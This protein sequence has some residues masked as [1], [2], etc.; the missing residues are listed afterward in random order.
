M[1]LVFMGTPEFSVPSLEILLANNYKIA[2]VV[3]APDTPQG[4][5]RRMMPSAIKVVARA[6]N[7]PILQPTNL[8]DPSFVDRLRSYQA[9][10]QVV[11]A[12]RMLPQIVWTMP[13][14]G[15]FNLHASL[16]PAYRGA[17]PINWAI[18]NGEHET[19]ITTFLLAQAM[20]TGD[21]LFQEK[22]PI[23][24]YD[25][26]GTLHERLKYKG[27]QLVLR[28]VQAVEAKNYTAMIQ[29]PTTEDLY[30]KAPK[31]YKKDCRINWAQKSAFI[32]NFIRGLSP[33]PAAWTILNGKT[34]KILYAE[35]AQ[36]VLP[37]LGP[38]ELHSDGEHYVCIGTGDDPVALKQLQLAGSRPKEVKEFLRGHKI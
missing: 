9:T 34:Y 17:A 30:K 6:H 15:T 37:N 19:G 4:R 10:L 20:D 29:A 25:T 18:I 11:V 23:Y 21:I 13:A 35:R 33:Y 12:F 28:T 8:Q 22:E 26:A 1:R 27:A 2:A 3:T 24:P 36:K 5:G 32:L 16:L 31:I 14:L 7:I 38:G